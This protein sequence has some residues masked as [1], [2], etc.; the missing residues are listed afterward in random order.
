MHA[1]VD[2]HVG[3]FWAAKLLET[4]VESLHGAHVVRT[5]GDVPSPEHGGPSGN[6]MWNIMTTC[7]P[8]FHSAWAIFHSNLPHSN[9]CQY[10][11][12]S[13]C[14][15]IC[16]CYTEPAPL[17]EKKKSISLCVG[18]TCVGQ[19]PVS[20]FFGIKSFQSTPHSFQLCCLFV[21]YCVLIALLYYYQ[22][23]ANRGSS[24]SIKT[25]FSLFQSCPLSHTSF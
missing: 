3:C 2:G 13:G 14:F 5:P 10:Y 8:F 22:L 9:L 12:F 7:Q 11:L 4:F 16:M 17:I 6:S 15:F 23:L 20:I 18:S 1:T 21:C 19:R 25:V 24:H